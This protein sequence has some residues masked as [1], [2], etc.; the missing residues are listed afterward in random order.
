MATLVKVEKIK[1]N[2]VF[3]NRYTSPNANSVFLKLCF[4][5]VNLDLKHE[6]H[7]YN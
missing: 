6:I 1:N 5:D 7:Y 3:K 4:P 2:K